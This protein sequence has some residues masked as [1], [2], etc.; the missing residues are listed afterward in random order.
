MN[1]RIH[2]P[3]NGLWLEVTN[4]MGVSFE[5]AREESA[6]DLIAY[7]N[8]PLEISLRVK[9]YLE[10]VAQEH[11]DGEDVDDVR[12]TIWS[13]L[14]KSERDVANKIVSAVFENYL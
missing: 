14:S 2:N 5:V 10:T 3:H 6:R 1:W 9:G 8:R 7:L 13:L 11:V 4:D 12:D